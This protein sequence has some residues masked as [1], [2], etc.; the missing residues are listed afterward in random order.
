M[1]AAFAHAGGS[2]THAWLDTGPRTDR[3]TLTLLGPII[4]W[5]RHDRPTIAPTGSRWAGIA[6]PG[7]G[8]VDR[9]R[10]PALV[11]IQDPRHDPHLLLTAAAWWQQQFLLVTALMAPGPC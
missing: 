4:D 1:L 9:R 8:M 10:R 6:R 5:P 3:C 11:E 7:T 2:H